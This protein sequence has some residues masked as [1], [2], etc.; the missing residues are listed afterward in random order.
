M[1]SGTFLAC[2]RVVVNEDRKSSLSTDFIET[3]WCSYR[4]V[5][6]FAILPTKTIDAGVVWGRNYWEHERRWGF[7]FVDRFRYA[8]GLP[9]QLKALE[10][11]DDRPSDSSKR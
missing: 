8:N 10:S 7:G 11:R 3:G 4:N 5:P 2:C 1:E 6:R 9:D